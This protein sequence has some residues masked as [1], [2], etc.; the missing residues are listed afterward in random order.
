MVGRGRMAVAT[1]LTAIFQFLPV[2]P[3]SSRT[4]E[5]SRERERGKG[6][7]VYDRNGYSSI[8]ARPVAPLPCVCNLEERGHSPGGS[9][10]LA[11]GTKNRGLYTLPVRCHPVR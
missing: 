1:R 2:I 7:R 8:R 4:H 6:A 3:P 9:R 11:A 5:R 10:A